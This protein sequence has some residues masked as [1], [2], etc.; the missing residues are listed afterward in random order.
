MAYC[1]LGLFDVNMPL[2]YGEGQKAFMR[3]Q[4]EIL[5]R[6]DD[7]TIFLGHL[8]SHQTPLS[9]IHQRYLLDPSDDFLVVN[10]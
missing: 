9:V 8:S 4:E 1:L 3:L 5:R 6:T 10:P 2:L 7:H